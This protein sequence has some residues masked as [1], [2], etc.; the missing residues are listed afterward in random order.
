MFTPTFSQ[1]IEDCNLEVIFFD[2][3]SRAKEFISR[4]NDG[5]ITAVKKIIIMEK[6]EN[7]KGNIEIPEKIQVI[8]L[9][10]Y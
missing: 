6:T 7:A 9:F 10:P 8:F 4:I 2:K 1:I 3:A 5:Y